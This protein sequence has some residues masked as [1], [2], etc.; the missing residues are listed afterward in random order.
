MQVI[1]IGRILQQMIIKYR[2]NY[3]LNEQLWLDVRMNESKLR[4]KTK[5][6]VKKIET[7]N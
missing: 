2:G 5:S 1:T 7:S 3:T 6:P 4:E